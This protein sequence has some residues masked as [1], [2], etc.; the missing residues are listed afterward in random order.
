MCVCVCMRVHLLIT[1][2]YSRASLIGAVV[3]IAAGQVGGIAHKL[4]DQP[5]CI[6]S[7]SSSSSSS[8]PVACDTLH[9]IPWSTCPEGVPLAP[10]N[11]VVL[12]CAAAAAVIAFTWTENTGGGGGPAATAAREGGQLMTAVKR[13]VCVCVCLCVC[14]RACVRV[15]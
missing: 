8:S 12:C 4:S 10:F 14:V 13:C 1:T 15:L 3:A 6:S 9:T 11:L 5:L 2:T 7:S